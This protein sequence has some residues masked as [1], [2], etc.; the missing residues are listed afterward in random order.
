M[1]RLRAHQYGAFA[2]YNGDGRLR[3][4]H[5]GGS[6]MR[7]FFCR[8]LTVALGLIVLSL[9]ARAR[10]ADEK[11]HPIVATVKAALKDTSKPFTLLVSLKVKDGNEEKFEKAFAKAAAGTRKEKGCKQ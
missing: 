11:P 5:Q 7:S 9:S 10:A 8:H 4:S 2:S 3:S 1:F 6:S